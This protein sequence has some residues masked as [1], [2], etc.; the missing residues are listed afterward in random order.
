MKGPAQIR[1][2]VSEEELLAWVRE[3]AER[4][5]YQKRLAIWLTKIGPFHAQEVAGCLGFPNRRCG[6]GSANTT[7]RALRDSH[8]K[9]GG[10]GVGPCYRG[11]KKKPFLGHL[12]RGR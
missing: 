5:A 9:V 12:K 11:Q 7:R 8:A 2:W 3:A 4:E 10:A 1:S 6:Y